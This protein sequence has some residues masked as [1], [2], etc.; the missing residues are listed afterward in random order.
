MG[1]KQKTSIEPAGAGQ[2]AI[3]TSGIPGWG[4]DADPENDPT[5]P[6]RERDKDDRSG[7]WDRPARQEPNVE[8]LSSIEHKRLPA[9]F[10][11]TVPPSGVSG[12]LRRAAFKYSESNWAHWLM[13]MGAD[14]VNVLEGVLQDLGRGKIPNVPAEMGVKSEYRHNK[15]GLVTKLAVIGGVAAV[16]VALSRRRSSRA[17]E[18]EPASDYDE[19]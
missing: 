1:K 12:M 10:G 11:T 4:V 7:E 2:T 16:A 13:L 5:Y 17:P 6:Y 18:R 14:R 3:D 9:V 19:N 15:S 8:V